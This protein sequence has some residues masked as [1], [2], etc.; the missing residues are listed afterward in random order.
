MPSSFKSIPI[1]IK[2]CTFESMDDLLID[3]K[4]FYVEISPIKYL[5]CTNAKIDRLSL[6]LTIDNTYASNTMTGI[7]TV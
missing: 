2:L 3:R 7:I 4:K 1:E 5:I 6:R